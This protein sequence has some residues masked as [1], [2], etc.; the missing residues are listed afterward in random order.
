MDVLSIVTALA[1]ILLAGSLAS[2]LGAK[3]R[4]PDVLLLLITGV[5]LSIITFGGERVLSF[6]PLFLTSIGVIALALILFD[7]MARVKLRE[8]DSFSF[9]ALK[10]VL[11]FT[12]LILVGFSAA[13]HY[14]AGFSW[15]LALLLAALL[16][17]TS[18]DIVL[19]LLGTSKHH[20]IELLKLESIFNTPLTVLLPFIVLDIAGGFEAGVTQEFVTHFARFL[21]ELVS[22]IGAGVIVALVLL[23]VIKKA[24]NTPYEFLAIIVAILVSYVLAENLNGNG[25]LAVT[26]LGL[27]FGNSILKDK[28]HLLT[29][30][31][32]IARSLYIFVF[33]L[34]GLVL[35]L[36]LTLEFFLS[37][38]S[39]FGVYLLIR[40]VAVGLSVKSSFKELIF[41]TLNCSKGVATA[42][43]LFAL[44]LLPT[45]ESLVR[46]LDYALAIILYS[47]LAASLAA[48]ASK[49]LIG[50]V[51]E[52]AA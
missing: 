10:L 15:W 23:K 3:L 47:I 20:T 5:C 48:W 26:T 30:E 38:L 34:L 16:S 46:V 18:P 49:K 8:L 31:S 35:S 13:A 41:A 7:S 28:R 50:E 19:S 27:F 2:W 36:P 33:V 22:G 14:L 29:F 52:K 9:K 6:P 51:V 32:L 44:A 40:F 11:V 42:T 24:H 4:I 17:G 37:S 43:V 1:I 39:L 21:T 45:A 25:V 12:L